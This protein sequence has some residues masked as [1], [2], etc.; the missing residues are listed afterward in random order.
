MNAKTTSTVFLILATFL[1]AQATLAD[2]RTVCCPMAGS[3]V[4]IPSPAGYSVMAAMTTGTTAIPMSGK[5]KDSDNLTWKEVDKIELDP[6]Q[7]GVH[8]LRCFY[9]DDK[10]TGSLFLHGI[11]ND[12]TNCT[13]PPGCSP[14]VPCCLTCT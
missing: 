13:L 9:G 14:E 7:P 8:N 10:G 4:K 1:G 12:A 5:S 11:L 2:P 6:S 3:L